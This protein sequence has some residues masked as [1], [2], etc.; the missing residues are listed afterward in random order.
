MPHKL[1]IEIAPLLEAMDG[2]AYLAD[3]SGIVAAVGTRNWNAFAFENGAPELD[4]ASVI[5]RNI[6]DF[7]SG[8]EVQQTLKQSMHRASSDRNYRWI[9]PFRCDSPT[10]LR[11]MRQTLSPIFT[12]ESCTG[13]IFQ[14]IELD[15][16]KR[17]PIDIYDFKEIERRAVLDSS[18][19]TVV[20]C[21]WCLRVRFEPLGTDDWME[22][23]AYYAAGGRSEIRLSHSICDTCSET[24]M[25]TTA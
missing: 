18:L 14:S 16:Y 13:F 4:A 23:E 12:D 5:G 2:I 19:P 8:E 1:N 6:L 3:C 15:S 21:S 9:A 24:I 7:I 20:M 17:P 25:T 11:N 10:C 22:A